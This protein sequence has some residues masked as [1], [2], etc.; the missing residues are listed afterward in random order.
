VDTGVNITGNLFEGI[1]DDA[2]FIRL[3]E[4]KT[5]EE[6]DVPLLGDES[7][8]ASGHNQ[9]R[10]VLRNFVTNMSS[11][12][13][14]AEVNDWGIYTASEIADKVTGSVDFEPFIKLNSPPGDVNFTGD[15]D[16]SDI[17]SVINDAL[18]ID[19]GLECD[20]DDNGS[21]NAVDVQI[22]INAALGM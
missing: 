12:E 20:L 10:N 18:G 13:T 17:Q 14:R 5:K 9:F 21:V 15:V 11:I 8:P 16:A 2:V 1:L 19:T 6:T 3:P 7:D 4:A 22:V